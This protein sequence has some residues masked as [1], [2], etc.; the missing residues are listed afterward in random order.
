MSYGGRGQ[1]LHMKAGDVGRS[2]AGRRAEGS[3]R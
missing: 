3:R 2:A 1:L